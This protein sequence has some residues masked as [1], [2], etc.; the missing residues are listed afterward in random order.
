M[1]VNDMNDQ[2]IIHQLDE[3]DM[4]DDSDPGSAD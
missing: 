1:I 2:V 4:D 3:D